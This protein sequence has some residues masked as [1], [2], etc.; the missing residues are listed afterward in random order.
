MAHNWCENFMKLTFDVFFD[1]F[2]LT[3][4]WNLNFNDFLKFKYLNGVKL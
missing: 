1:I 3:A 2:F 4:F